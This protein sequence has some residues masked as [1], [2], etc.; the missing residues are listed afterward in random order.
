MTPSSEPRG[1]RI[2][3]V[4]PVQQ[5]EKIRSQHVWSVTYILRSLYNPWV[6]FLEDYFIGLRLRSKYRGKVIV[7]KFLIKN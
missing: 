1:E 5:I 3:T 4:D 7:E 2:D 6:M